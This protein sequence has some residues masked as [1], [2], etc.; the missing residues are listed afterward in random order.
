MVKKNGV[1]LSTFSWLA[2]I[3]FLIAGCLLFGSTWGYAAEKSVAEE[4][5]DVLKAGNQISE[6]QY[7]LL[8]QKARAEKLELQKEREALRKER[9]ALKVEKQGMA[10]LA[11]EDVKDNDL[12]T[13]WKEGLRF[14]SRDKQFKIKVGGRIQADFASISADNDIEDAFTSDF[15]GHGT[16][17]RR[18]RLFVSGTLYDDIIFKAQYDFA[19]G[20]ADFNDMWLG[21]N[22]LPMVGRVRIGHQKEPLSLEALTS[23]NHNPFMERGLPNAFSPGR[24][25]GIGFNDAVLENRMTW[26]LGFYQNVGSF[27]GSFSDTADFNLT[28]RI[29]GLPY[30]ERKGR[31]LVHLGVGYS[32]QF[33]NDSGNGTSI[34]YRARPESNLANR[35]VD[36]GP[37]AADGVDLYNA[38][39]AMVWGPLSL[40]GECFYSAV[41]SNTAGDPNFSGYYAL[42]SYF[43][44]GE[45]RPY[46]AKMGSFGRLKPKNDYDLSN[47][48]YGAWELAARY[49]SI[50]LNDAGIQGGE[51]A[52][53]TLGINWYLNPN[54]RVTLNWVHAEIEDRTQGVTIGDGSA[55]IV[56]SRFQVDF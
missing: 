32:H 41:D 54:S 28:G 4:I 50:D 9:A 56:Q 22:N 36:T 14:D 49:S 20:D 27:G 45:Y 10:P 19:G 1:F 5:L 40:Q 34:Q 43:L 39:A 29:S 53:F 46:N 52:D 23:S 35:L 15:Q 55:D 33:R 26:G 48:S 51:V 25:T 7:N 8:M 6:V 38:E 17:F 42:I 3:V 30:F 47:G 37:I 18:A 16:E 24:N 44:T 21:L 2:L 31:E 11:V 12:H 13:F